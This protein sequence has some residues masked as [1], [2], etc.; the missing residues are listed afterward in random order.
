M[1]ICVCVPDNVSVAAPL[2]PAAI[3]APPERL[4]VT[5]PCRTVSCTVARLTSPSVV[6]IPVMARAV[7]SLTVLLPGTVFTGAALVVITVMEI[8]ASAEYWAPS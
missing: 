3:A 2:E 5:V 8:T 6:L 4:T 7:S 1:L